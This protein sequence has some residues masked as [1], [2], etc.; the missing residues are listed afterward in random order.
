[1]NITAN[2]AFKLDIEKYHYDIIRKS[3]T[4]ERLITVIMRNKKGGLR[5]VFSEYINVAIK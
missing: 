3:D 1:M 4:D 2:P 5:K